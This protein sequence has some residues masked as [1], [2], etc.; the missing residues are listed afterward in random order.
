MI[1]LI[2]VVTIF[3]FLLQPSFAQV[4]ANSLTIEVSKDGEATVTEQITPST[5]VSRITVDAITSD[6]SNILAVDENNVVLTYS[7][8][9]D[10][11]TIDTL[12]SASVTL[13]Y[14]A[15]IVRK[16]SSDIW[17]LNYDSSG[18]QSTVVLPSASD[19]IDVS[20]IPIDIV[21]NVVTMPAGETSLRYK[22]KSL[23]TKNFVV[24]WDD[25]EYLVHIVTA[26]IVQG[27]SFE[28]SSK[29]LVLTLDTS[30]PML[31]IIPKELLG[32][33]YS[34]T[35]SAGDPVDFKQYYQNSTHSWIRVEPN[36]RNT[37]KIV[38]TTVVPELPF[39]VISAGV[40]IAVVL[41]LATLGK[42]LNFGTSLSSIRRL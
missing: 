34:V 7:N 18:M 6:I 17:E 10:Q 13:T 42:K 36:D 19:L 37:I 1:K 16:V 28:Q 22:I 2:V 21:G 24:E 26:S 33:P 4:Q 27:F 5:S 11:I 38:G 29:S 15:G 20:E 41:L 9:N 25:K 39:Q 14:S 30:T 35:G 3:L 8:A 12:G 32:G 23:D 40:A 31:A